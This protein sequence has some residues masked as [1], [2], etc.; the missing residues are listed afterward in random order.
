MP[1]VKTEEL[2][3]FRRRQP[4]EYPLV[5]FRSDKGT[6]A[7]LEKGVESLIKILKKDPR[8]SRF[9]KNDIYMTCLDLGIDFLF[10]LATSKSEDS[11]KRVDRLVKKVHLRR[12]LQWAKDKA[13]RDFETKIKKH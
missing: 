2:P 9:R 7:E 5:Q 13:P 8:F 10:T 11:V 1:K 6:K 4:S 3:R 12:E